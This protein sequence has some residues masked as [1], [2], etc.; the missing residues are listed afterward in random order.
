MSANIKVLFEATGESGLTKLAAPGRGIQAVPIG[1][2]G[3]K[4][5]QGDSK[6]RTIEL[7]TWGANRIL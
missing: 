5:S 4:E 2:P 1:Q 7:V 3:F 6:N